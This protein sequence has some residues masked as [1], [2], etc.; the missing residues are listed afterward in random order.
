MGWSGHFTGLL[1]VAIVVL[2]P[3]WLFL[4][5]R[6]RNLAFRDEGD[7]SRKLDELTDLAGRMQARIDV[8]E[9]LLEAAPGN[10]GKQQ[11]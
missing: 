2:G 6:S 1:I 8:L 10:K 3:I 4:H 9:R 11:P 5:Y 7:L